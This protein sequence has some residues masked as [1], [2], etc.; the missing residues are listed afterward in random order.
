MWI[1]FH[2]RHKIHYIAI[3][4]RSEIANKHPFLE[5]NQRVAF[6]TTHT[7]LLVNGYDLDGDARWLTPAG[8]VIPRLGFVLQN[9]RV[10]N[11]LEL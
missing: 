4:L 7:L 10:C 8:P 1:N 11:T 9:C 2:V 3:R 6:A 5:G